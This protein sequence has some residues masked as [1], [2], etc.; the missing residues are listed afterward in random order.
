MGI[1]AVVRDPWNGMLRFI[2]IT[3]S[4]DSHKS[5]LLGVGENG[6]I[7]LILQMSKQVSLRVVK[8]SQ[9][10][11]PGRGR[12]KMLTLQSFQVEQIITTQFLPETCT[13]Y[14][15]A[16]RNPTRHPHCL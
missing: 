11:H 12:G 4:P 8:Y 1:R 10:P 2:N 14:A 16:N 5:P 9:D 3:I 6:E 7:I 13:E 15:F